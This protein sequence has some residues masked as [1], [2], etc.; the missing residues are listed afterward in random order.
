MRGC[1]LG[2]TNL[3]SY[4]FMTSLWITEESFDC[5]EKFDCRR[6]SCAESKHARSI[7][8][9][10]VMLGRGSDNAAGRKTQY[11]KTCPGLKRQNI[12]S[13]SGVGSQTAISQ[14]SLAASGCDL[15]SAFSPAI[16]DERKRNGE[17][18]TGDEST[19]TRWADGVLGTASAALSKS[20]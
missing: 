7:V 6:Y 16:M 11:T 10:T 19:R 12:R 17:E 1:V 2:W 20:L 3:V 18:D 9:T 8:I 14:T 4:S 13:E 15:L 5:W